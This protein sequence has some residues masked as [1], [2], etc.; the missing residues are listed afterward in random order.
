M[1][2]VFY[3]KIFP[4]AIVD[5]QQYRLFLERGWYRVQQ[6][7][8]TTDFI[9]I[10]G[11]PR[12]NAQEIE[13]EGHFQYLE[14]EV[15][16]VFWLRVNLQKLQKQ[17]KHPYH[18]YIQQHF[19]IETTAFEYQ[20]PYEDLYAKYYNGVDFDASPTLFNYLF[21]HEGNDHFNSTAINLYHQDQLIAFGIFDEGLNCSAGIINCFDP[22]YK[23]YGLGNWLI[24]Q[25]IQF[26]LQ[27]QHDYYYPGYFCTRVPK[28]D[29]KLKIAQ[30][31]TEVWIRE[32]Q[33]WI[34]YQPS[35]LPK[36]ENY[37]I[38]TF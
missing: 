32:A 11:M 12:R 2:S 24:Q 8:M 15:G 4:Q 35:L 14:V 21:D 5:K 23:K 3:Q 7:L 30:E 33:Q 31:A 17:K 18:N 26:G 29:Y 28:F 1:P 20:Q 37:L 9:V 13:F 25:K 34:A 27:N 19:R 36:L 10:D 16:P 38:H 6:I 22:A